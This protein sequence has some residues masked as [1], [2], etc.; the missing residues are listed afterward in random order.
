[1]YLQQSNSSTK[2]INNNLYQ[3]FYV[4][5]LDSSDSE[6]SGCYSP[7]CS[8][9]EEEGE[10]SSAVK[11]G[12]ETV[13]MAHDLEELIMGDEESNNEPPNEGT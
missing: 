13:Q 8:D 4:H 10:G 7:V 11:S 1:M 2:E 6:V 9:S 12:I 3:Y 5:V